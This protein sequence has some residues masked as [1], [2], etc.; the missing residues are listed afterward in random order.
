MPDKEF[1]LVGRDWCKYN[2]FD[3]LLSLPNFKYFDNIPYEKYPN[4][5]HEMDVFV[6][7]S[8]LEGGP[9]PLLEAML[10]N[11]VPVATKT[12]FG[13]D[14]IEH[15]KNGYLFESTDNVQHII[16]LIR[17]AF[18]IKADVRSYAEPHSWKSYGMKIKELF[19][20][21]PDKQRIWN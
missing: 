11:I 1:I 20:G 21:I 9:V 13:P 19:A 18:E 5:Y 7:P 15:G 16:Q 3:E 10:C 14:L 17:Q 6:S 2:R 8:H 12:G 4:L